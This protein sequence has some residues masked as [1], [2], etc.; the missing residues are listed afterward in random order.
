M[1]VRTRFAGLRL[2]WLIR[3]YLKKNS[4]RAADRQPLDIARKMDSNNRLKLLNKKL[5]I[6]F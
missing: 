6:P 3:T 4:V 5:D 2:P 1:A